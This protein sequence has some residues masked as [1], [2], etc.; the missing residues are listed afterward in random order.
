MQ[1][2]I[3]NSNEYINWIEEAISTGNIKCYDYG[4]FRNIKEISIGSLGKVY[5]ANWNNFKDH[6]ALKSFYNLNKITAKEIV[7]EV[8]YFNVTSL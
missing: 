2:N 5:C 6:M 3:D 8:L 4:R 1:A 7:H